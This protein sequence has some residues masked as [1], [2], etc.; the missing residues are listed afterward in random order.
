MKKIISLAFA[1]I[2]LLQLLVAQVSKEQVLQEIKS[3]G[4]ANI[5]ENS[6]LINNQYTDEQTGFTHVY[7]KQAVN[8]MEVVNT[9]SSLHF[10]KNGKL[11][12]TTID[13]AGVT[14]KA[15][16]PATISAETA[17]KIA[18][19]QAG[20][21]L[22][23]LSKTAI[24][25]DANKS[26]M[27]PAH[28]ISSEPIRGKFCYYSNGTELLPAWQ[29]EILNDAT[30]DWLN[31]LVNAASG[32]ILNQINYTNKCNIETMGSSTKS[33]EYF[34]LFDEKESGKLHAANYHVIAL[35]GESPTHGGRAIVANPST[36]NASPYG[37]HDTDGVDGAEFTITRG[38]NVWAKEDT[39]SNNGNGYSPNGDSSL[40]FE[41]PYNST[42]SPR[43]NLNAAITNLFYIN[44][45]MHDI[46]YNYGF[47]EAAGNFQTNNY[48]KGGLDKDEMRSEAQDEG[49]SGANISVPIDGS[50]CRMQMTLYRPFGAIVNNFRI[51]TPG[52][53][54][55]YS[56]YISIFG[57]RPPVQGITSNLVWANDSSSKPTEAC[58]ELKNTSEVAGKIVLIERGA[59]D[60]I[61]NGC[62]YRQKIL[63]AQNAGAIG[64]IF[65][66]Y[67]SSVY[68]GATGDTNGIN[69]PSIIVSNI[70]GDILKN[71]MKAGTVNVSMYDSSMFGPIYD[72]DL[73]NGIIAHEY[74]HGISIRLTGG[75]ANSSCLYNAE[76]GG[77]GWSD[78]FALYVSAKPWE[79]L[80]SGRGMGN[81][82]LGEDTNG[83]G[84]RH[85]KYSRNKTINPATYKNVAIYRET[86]GVGFV[87]CTML[88]DLMLN[89]IDKYGFDTDFYNGTGGNNKTLQIIMMGLKLQKCGP[90][91]VD[92]RNAIIAAD[93]ALNGGA[94]YAMIWKTFANRGLGY[95][96]IQGSSSS[97][98]D[99]TEAFDLPPVLSTGENM[100]TTGIS[101]YPNPNHGI[102]KLFVS[103]PTNNVQIEIYNILGILVHKQTAISEL[104]TVDLSDQANGLY[105]VKITD[106]KNIVT[107]KIIKQ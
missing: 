11:F 86:H 16:T 70:T 93:S 51:N 5:D 22:N 81:Y 50:S 78:F 3:K 58:N 6:F 88:Y 2:C 90:G 67:F 91:F 52:T 89:M 85:Y 80:L 33:N 35:P 87:W 38:N 26:F 20:I 74:G 71:Y 99:Q 76:S 25:L 18:S 43:T 59:S 64:V 10:N 55:L 72:S 21:H 73:D 41:F 32:A 66:S 30:S 12:Y 82:A 103:Y 42:A 15:N 69:I 77:E 28:G 36:F 14:L 63:N 107:Q 19:V 44:N 8:G 65:I 48:N 95:S 37:W 96:A 47:T 49:I 56:S 92:S 27:V 40:S 39:L 98:S 45:M 9:Q 13:F 1:L 101:I 75:P 24:I 83:L 97:V 53:N 31:I 106:G 79:T 105:F 100:E 61:P 46:M 23:Q 94:N 17:L 54:T 29:F 102:F 60:I 68:N 84:S 57:P 4:F 7:F 104:N 62:S 34:F